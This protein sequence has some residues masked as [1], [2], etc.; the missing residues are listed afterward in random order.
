[1]TTTSPDVVAL[2]AQYS[3]LYKTVY[4]FRPSGAI[5]GDPE[6]G[7]RQNVVLASF[8]KSQVQA[9]ERRY[10]DSPEKK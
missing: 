9:V 10:S 4:Y 6:G 8:S 2:C 7:A 1:M 3:L 5:F